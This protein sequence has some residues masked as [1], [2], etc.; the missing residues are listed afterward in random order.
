[1]G[2]YGYSFLAKGPSE[3]RAPMP[4]LAPTD[5]AVPEQPWLSP[6]LLT[7]AVLAVAGASW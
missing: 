1:M 4:L 3:T 5:E 7:A 6:T 2:E